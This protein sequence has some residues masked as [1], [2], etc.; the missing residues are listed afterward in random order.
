MFLQKSSRSSASS[1]PSRRSRASSPLRLDSEADFT[2]D[3]LTPQS[4]SASEEGDA[5]DRIGDKVRFRIRKSVGAGSVAQCVQRVFRTHAVGRGG[6]LN[7]AELERGLKELL[8]DDLASN[9]VTAGDLT[10]LIARFDLDGDGCVDFDE[11]VSVV[12]RTSWAVCEW[13]TS[14]SERAFPRS[15]SRPPAAY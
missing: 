10:K 11:L 8:N 15:L 5:T 4:D 12:F 14:C 2:D 6:A 13:V 9:R 1:S 3:E 7:T